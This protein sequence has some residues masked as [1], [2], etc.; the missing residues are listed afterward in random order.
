[1]ATINNAYSHPLV[2]YQAGPIITDSFV[3]KI[4]EVFVTTLITKSKDDK[5]YYYKN[6]EVFTVTAKGKKVE[7]GWDKQTRHWYTDHKICWVMNNFLK[8]FPSLTGKELKNLDKATLSSIESYLVG[9]PDFLRHLRFSPPVFECQYE[10]SKPFALKERNIAIPGKNVLGIS[11][12]NLNQLFADLL[13]DNKGVFVGVEYSQLETKVGI[14]NGQM[15]SLKKANVKHIYIGLPATMYPEFEDYNLNPKASEEDL[16]ATIKKTEHGSGEATMSLCRAAK[17]QGIH[18]WPVD[19]N[20]MTNILA[21]RLKYGAGSMIRNI[22]YFSGQLKP[23]EKYIAILSQPFHQV[24]RELGLPNVQFGQKL[25][26]SN[27]EDDDVNDIMAHLFTRAILS[28][29]MAPEKSSFLNYLYGLQFTS[30]QRNEMKGAPDFIISF[31]DSEMSRSETRNVAG[32]LVT[33]WHGMQNINNSCYIASAIQAISASSFLKTRIALP[34]VRGAEESESHF[35]EREKVQKA[36]ITLLNAL[37]NGKE[38]PKHLRNFRSALF[39]NKTLNSDLSLYGEYQQEGVFNR[40]LMKRVSPLNAQQDAAQLM[41]LIFEVLDLNV[42]QQEL[43]YGE[44]E[45]VGQP[46]ITAEKMI[47]LPL[48]G[49][50]LQDILNQRFQRN[51]AA[52]GQY[53]EVGD[54]KVCKVEEESRILGTP[55]ILVVRLKRF[56]WDQQSSCPLK[57]CALVALPAN[58]E[59][60]LSAAFKSEEPQPYRIASII[61]HSGNTLFSGHYI[62]HIR[63]G[64]EWVTCDDDSVYHSNSDT[65]NDND[66]FQNY[67]FILERKN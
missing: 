2:S 10:F 9:A 63:Q 52:P 21:E 47:E 66:L 5:V 50:S 23:E 55:E 58:L 48:S 42:Y 36:L 13:K 32:K 54:S 67:L 49:S 64:N 8:K 30:K 22:D 12:N 45:V 62:A 57:N 25:P 28:D 1:M 44:N 59:V 14:L 33:N 19:S 4:L 27:S 16:F 6:D 26:S 17:K 39:A 31:K 51:Q 15:E 43:W 53:I 18:I 46:P 11:I 20:Y 24:A 37:E 41:Q 40:D 34:L 61:S 29:H 65:I 38:L 35:S 3:S 56:G 60:D 7:L